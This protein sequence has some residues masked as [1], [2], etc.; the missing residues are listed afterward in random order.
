MKSVLLFLLTTLFALA[1]HSK[2]PKIFEESDHCVAW[3]TKKRMFLVSSQEPV[4]KNCSITVSLKEDTDGKFALEGVFP[5]D[6]F[7]SGEKD[8]DA[9]VLLILGAEKQKN[10]EFLSSAMTKEE[11]MNLISSSEAY[12]M[13][14][15]LKIAGKEFDVS[16]EVETRGEGDNKR[17]FGHLHS[18]FST[19]N[20]EPPSVAGGMVAKVRDTLK[21]SFMFQE[22]K[23]FGAEKLKAE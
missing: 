4:G 7:D 13:A 22:A 9:E 1:S 6:K 3:K 12:A 5:I 23:I 20:I 15:K 21:L 18:K 11:W 19:F 14:G 8:R 17:Y 16:F 2:G 10:L